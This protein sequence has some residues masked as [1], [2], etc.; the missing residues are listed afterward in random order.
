MKILLTGAQGQ[1]GRC[2]IDEVNARNHAGDSG[3]M[4]LDAC[5]SQDLDISDVDAVKRRV[6]I[7]KPDFVI[8]AAAYTAVDKAESE[9]EMAYQVNE[10][11]PR[12]LAM[13]CSEQDIPLIHVSTDYVFDGQA[14]VPYKETDKVAPQSVYGASKLAGERAVASEC[15]KYVIVRT[16]WVFSEYG[17]NFVKTMLR[18]AGGRDSVSVVSDQLGCPTYARDIASA[19]VDLCHTKSPGWGLYH[20]VGRS[21]MSWSDFAQA[22]FV[23][24]EQEGMLDKRMDVSPITT[25]EYPTPATR[26]GYSVLDT[27]FIQKTFGVRPRLL[28]DSLPQMM[29]RLATMPMECGVRQC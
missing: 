27:G 25:D 8:N 14:S 10:Q 17:N 29:H 18:L 3:V 4:A 22:I 21:I 15:E 23:L 5:G 9:P 28:E 2:L 20:Y 1:L 11:G 24:A 13:L 12:N 16:A 7:S 19:L 26:P 6:E